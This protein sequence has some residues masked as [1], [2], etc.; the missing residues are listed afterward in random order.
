MQLYNVV[1]DNEETG[2]LL[3]EKGNLRRRCTIIPIAKIKGSVISEDKIK[4]AK[5]LVSLSVGIGSVL[6]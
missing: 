6:L 1:V 2:K 5:Q 3:L 4:R